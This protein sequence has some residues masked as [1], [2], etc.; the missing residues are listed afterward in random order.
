MENNMNLDNVEF[1]KNCRDEFLRAVSDEICRT[2]NKP[3]KNIKEIDYI[4]PLNC[5]CRC[6]RVEK[7]L[8][9]ASNIDTDIKNFINNG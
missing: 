2:C 3:Q 6:E 4:N 7:I 1:Y 9:I 8:V 5:E